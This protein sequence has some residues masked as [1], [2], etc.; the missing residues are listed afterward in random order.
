M[1]EGIVNRSADVLAA[2]HLKNDETTTRIEKPWLCFSQIQA[3]SGSPCDKPGIDVAIGR[4]V[5]RRDFSRVQYLQIQNAQM[6]SKTSSQRAPMCNYSPKTR[7]RRNGKFSGQE[8]LHTVQLP[9]RWRRC[10]CQ[11]ASRTRLARPPCSG[12]PPAAQSP[13]HWGPPA[14]HTTHNTKSISKALQCI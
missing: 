1:G 4:Y 8:G 6:N 9:G 10:A 12:C 13:S 11:W 5:F 2:A 7:G 14:P 3:T